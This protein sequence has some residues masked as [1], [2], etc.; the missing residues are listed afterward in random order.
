MTSWQRFYVIFMMGLNVVFLTADNN[1]LAAVLTS[2][3]KEFSVD[4][5]DI[6]LISFFFSVVG[7]AVSLYWGFYIDKVNR[8]YLFA[9]SIFIAEIPCLLTAFAPNFTVFFILRV[10]TGI[11]VGAAFPIIFAM[12]GDLFDKKGRTLAAAIMNI[13]W[14]FGGVI[15][16]SIAGYTLENDL[17]WRLAFIL[18]AAPNFLFILIFLLTVKEPPKGSMEKGVGDLVEQGYVYPRTI[19]LKDYAK[20]VKIKTNFYLFLQGVAGNLPWGAMFLL[21]KFFTDE[22]GFSQGD[23]TSIYVL[24]GVGTAVGGL[25]G[26]IYGG[27]LFKKNPNYQP[28][29]ASISTAIGAVMLI[30]LL[31]Y[32]PAE[33]IIAMGAGFVGAVFAAMTGANMRNMLLSANAPEDRGAIFSV[34]NLTDAVG[35]GVGQFLAGMLAVYVGVTYSLVISF[36]FWFICSFFLYVVSRYFANDVRI[37]DGKMKRLAE[38]MRQ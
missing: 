16:V 12:V 33:L 36:S 32:L 6:G 27:Y 20:L 8:K 35:Y 2:L 38:E 29:Y 17:G 28:L 10:L 4:S 37:L 11:G 13:C 25:I 21:I 15:G 7:A 26:G 22:K 34:F 9:A 3:E 24:F 19:Q 14:G 5:G 23:A 31:L 18:V 1:I 30:L